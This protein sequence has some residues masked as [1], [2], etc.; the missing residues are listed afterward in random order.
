MEANCSQT[1][2]PV[3][4][5]QCGELICT[6]KLPVHLE[7]GHSIHPLSQEATNFNKILKEISDYK[8]SVVK[9]RESLTSTEELSSNQLTQLEDLKEKASK[10]LS[11]SEPTNADYEKFSQE[12]NSI[13]TS[14]GTQLAQLKQSIEG[15]NLEEAS[16]RTNEAPKTESFSG[17]E[18]INSKFNKEGASEEIPVFVSAG[19]DNTIKVW[20]DNQQV[21]VIE[22]HDS[23]IESMCV[24]D[25]ESVVTG[26]SDGTLKL[27]SIE[28]GNL[29]KTVAVHSGR[30]L[31]VSKSMDDTIVASGGEDCTV[32][33][34]DVDEEEER[35]SFE[36]HTDHVSVVLFPKDLESV[37]SGSKDTTIRVWGEFQNVI[38]GH[39]GTVYSLAFAKKD[40]LLV[41]ASEDETIRL[42]QYKTGDQIHVFSMSALSVAAP[43]KHGTFILSGENDGTVRI[44]DNQKK[45]Q[46]GVLESH[47][48]PVESIVLSEKQQ[49][50]FSGSKDG[51]IIV[52]R[53]PGPEVVA[54]MDAHPGGVHSII[55]IE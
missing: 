24:Y 14:L 6:H 30:V 16:S 4:Q 35:L 38:E 22:D 40:K 46:A 1:C 33:A 48:D 43:R 47:R 13:K 45:T 27:W 28:T 7:K 17:I 52:Q 50:V 55:L 41:S 39:T 18:S 9:L 49:F 10:L 5:C 12:F 44:W 54:R 34:W 19:Y 15:I 26:N 42:W 25:E 36:G 20:K 31:C 8:E 32:K 3:S 2:P 11:N 29:L 51:T 37:F 53:L 23:K 21:L